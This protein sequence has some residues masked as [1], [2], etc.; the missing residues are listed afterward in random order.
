MSKHLPRIEVISEE[1]SLEDVVMTHYKLHQRHEQV[2]R[3]VAEKE[4]PY[5]SLEKE[6]A[7]A[8]PR[9]KKSKL[10]REIIA[11]FNNLLPERT[12]RT[13]TYRAMQ[14]PFAAKPK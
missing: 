14:T 7:G 11:R 4:K 12:L 9:N 6:G 13:E 8:N 2:L 3:L 5:V 10:L 1:L